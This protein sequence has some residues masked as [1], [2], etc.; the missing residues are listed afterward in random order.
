MGQPHTHG[1]S[2]EHQLDRSESSSAGA[3]LQ[4]KAEPIVLCDGRQRS[5]RAAGCL[6]DQATR[7]DAQCADPP[8]AGPHGRTPKTKTASCPAADAS[9]GR[10]SFETCAGFTDQLPKT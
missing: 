8:T 2:W 5:R 9:L 7:V 1:W 6:R 3:R 10:P 4:R